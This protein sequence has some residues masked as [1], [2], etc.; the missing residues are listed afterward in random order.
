MRLSPTL[1]KKYRNYLI[2][3]LIIPNYL[4]CLVLLLFF[5]DRL[6]DIV[7]EKFSVKVSTAITESIDTQVAVVVSF[8]NNVDISTRDVKYLINN[9]TLTLNSS[10][11][12]IDFNS[13]KYIY[14]SK[15]VDVTEHDINSIKSIIGEGVTWVPPNRSFYDNS[16]VVIAAKADILNNEIIGAFIVELPI[17]IFMYNLKSNDIHRDLKVFIQDQNE[18]IIAL[19]RKINEP[20][21]YNNYFEDISLYTQEHKTLKISTDS[22]YLFESELSILDSKLLSL[23]PYE[24]ISHEI[25]PIIKI[26]LVLL[27][28][29]S[30]IITIGIIF[31][32]NGLLYKLNK[33]KNHLNEIEKGDLSPKQYIA[34]KD[35]FLSINSN[36]N[37]M[38]SKISSRIIELENSLSLNRELVDTRTTL[39]HLITHNCAT[40]VTV[41]LNTSQDLLIED[42]NKEE[43]RDIYYASNSIKNIIDNILTLLRL[44]EEIQNVNNSISVYSMT[45]DII[46][47]YRSQIENKS[48]KIKYDFP[49][50]FIVE[51]DSFFIRGVLMNLFDNAVKYSYIGSEIQI[52]CSRK[53]NYLEWVIHDGGPGFTRDE[54]DKLYRKFNRLSAR[55]TNGESSSGL[56]LHIAKRLSEKI[57]CKLEHIP[58]KNGAM[59]SFSMPVAE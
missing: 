21:E 6:T 19:N 13:N 20:I 49:K 40:P 52:S 9:V 3:F 51:S 25:N 5:K 11:G 44:D 17:E 14:Q 55:P 33:I 45:S 50:D 26:S 10:I 29:I 22:Y 35:E 36:I 59:F 31:L 48:L 15:N 32:F 47:G 8:L 7:Y 12:Y 23:L 28:I 38:A 2:V 4:L 46:S 27:L 39:L 34:Q 43:Y 56:G 41:L 37:K 42:S 1:S 16:L 24:Y 54:Y 53:L 30:T 58:T 57:N 18:K